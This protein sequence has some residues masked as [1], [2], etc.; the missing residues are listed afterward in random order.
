V[1]WA[2][3]GATA[4]GEKTNENSARRAGE[5]ASCGCVSVAGIYRDVCDLIEPAPNLIII[6][7]RERLLQ[8]RRVIPAP[9]RPFDD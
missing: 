6:S 1:Q 5:L 2:T 7:Q 3:D 8:N 9:G 4:Y